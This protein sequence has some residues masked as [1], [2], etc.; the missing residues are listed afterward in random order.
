[1]PYENEQE[2]EQAWLKLQKEQLQA[3]EEIAK[4]YEELP[5]WS[6]WFKRAFR[7]GISTLF[8]SS[9]TLRKGKDYVKKDELI[10]GQEKAKDAVNVQ[11]IDQWIEEVTRKHQILLELKEIEELIKE[12]D[13]SVTDPRLTPRWI[14]QNPDVPLLDLG[15]RDHELAGFIEK[16][17]AKLKCLNLAGQRIDGDQLKK[18]L[19]YCPRLTQ[20]SI[21]S[22]EIKIKTLKFLKR[23]L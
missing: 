9:N 3:S 17:G 5:D 16:Y 13:V 10:K 12:H 20:I 7:Y 11:K 21:N 8:M 1:M 19:S 6:N 4:S 18:L 2:A 23:C 22:N 15:L 14:N